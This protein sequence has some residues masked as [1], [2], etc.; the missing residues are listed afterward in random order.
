VR[1][2]NIIRP[3]GHKIKGKN[4]CGTEIALSVYE[5]SENE[6][7]MFHTEK[8]K[9]FS[10]CSFCRSGILHNFHQADFSCRNHVLPAGNFTS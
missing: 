5:A 2:G 6:K 8:W 10:T 7:N 9:N 1:T 4:A 3:C